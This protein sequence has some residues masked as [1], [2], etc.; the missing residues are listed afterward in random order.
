MCCNSRESHGIGAIRIQPRRVYWCK[1]K[2]KIGA[3]EKANGG[4]IFLDEIGEMPL[5]LQFKLLRTIQKKEIAKLGGNTL[6]KIDV[7]IIA[8]TNRDLWDM[9]T[10]NLFRKYLLSAE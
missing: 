9:V 10:Q 5:A 7:R 2:R 4:T 3:F 6:T 8:A 1:Q